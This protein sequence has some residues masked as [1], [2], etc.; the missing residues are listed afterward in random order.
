MIQ[1]KK[2][3]VIFIEIRIEN[4]IELWSQYHEMNWIVFGVYRY[5][6]T[7]DW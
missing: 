2:K 7:F 5:T 4:R 6:Q 1:K 3:G